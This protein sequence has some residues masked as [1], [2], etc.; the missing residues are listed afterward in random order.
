MAARRLS[1]MVAGRGYSSLSWGLLTA[2]ASLVAGHR[3]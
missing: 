1:E 2:G 3:L